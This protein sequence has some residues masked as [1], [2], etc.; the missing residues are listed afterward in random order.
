MTNT[1]SRVFGAFRFCSVLHRL[2]LRKLQKYFGLWLLHL[3]KE[4]K[5]KRS[6]ALGRMQKAEVFFVCSYYEYH[7]LIF[8]IAD[9][10]NVFYLYSLY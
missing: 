2:I 7:C 10:F 6:N 5:C 9:L 4:D 1:Y 3:W 8:V